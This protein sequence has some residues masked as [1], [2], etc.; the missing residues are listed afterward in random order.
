MTKD[1]HFI[2]ECTRGIHIKHCVSCIFRSA[3]FI[4]FHFGTCSFPN[5]FLLHAYVIG[6]SPRTWANV[7]LAGIVTFKLWTS[8]CLSSGGGVT[9]LHWTCR[10]AMDVELAQIEYIFRTGDLALVIGK[11]DHSM[12]VGV[13][14]CCVHCILQSSV[15]KRKNWRDAFHLKLAATTGL[16]WC[17]NS[18]S[19]PY[20]AT[21]A[22]HKSFNADT[23]EQGL[24]QAAQRY[25][26]SNHQMICFHPS[27]RLK[28]LRALRKRTTNPRLQKMLRLQIRNLHR[29]GK[30]CGSFCLDPLD[31]ILWCNLMIMVLHPCWRLCLPAHSTFG[32]AE[33]SDW[34]VVQFG[35][36]GSCG[37]WCSNTFQQNFLGKFVNVQWYPL[38]RHSASIVVL[39]CILFN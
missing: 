10:R 26:R 11:H 30:A 22:N 17:T 34:T 18:I 12:P 4:A 35:G 31:N 28:H 1:P 2:K 6:A 13:G 36:T 15:G 33:R 16:W 21:I 27:M 19:E 37:T 3:L 32:K 20:P 7:W 23:L 24:I 14:H 29:H 39:H 38:S 8:W 9:S 5:V 25:G